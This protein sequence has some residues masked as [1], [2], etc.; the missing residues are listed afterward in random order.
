MTSEADREQAL[1]ERLGRL[2]NPDNDPVIAEDLRI[3]WQGTPEEKMERIAEKIALNR[4][5]EQFA[6]IPEAHAGRP[7][8]NEKSLAEVASEA[9][10]FVDMKAKDIEEVL[11]D[12]KD[13]SDDLPEDME[14]ITEEENSSIEALR[15][16]LNEVE[17]LNQSMVLLAATLPKAEVKP[18]LGETL[19]EFFRDMREK[20]ARLAEWAVPLK[21]QLKTGSIHLLKLCTDVLTVA[22]KCLK[23][24]TSIGAYLA[25]KISD[26]SRDHSHKN[27]DE[28]TDSN[29]VRSAKAVGNAVGDTAELAL[30]V[31]GKT[32]TLALKGTG[33][34]LGVVID[35]LESFSKHLQDR[36]EQRAQAGPSHGR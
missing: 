20:A 4:L 36:L 13:L 18:D 34:V 27:K 9:V 16:K 29:A 32:A 10:E 7:S 14:D 25:D 6:T 17:T 26:I 1:Y 5:I 30:K 21:E 33:G 3:K 2:F 35:L 22:V 8:V 19:R 28:N 11:S 24:C 31:T 15:Q 23:F 12:C